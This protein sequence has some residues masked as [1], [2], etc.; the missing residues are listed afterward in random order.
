MIT[1]TDTDAES[2]IREAKRVLAEDLLRFVQNRGDECVFHALRSHLADQGVIPDPDAPQIDRFTG[3]FDPDIPPEAQATDPGHGSTIE[4]YLDHPDSVIAYL[5][6]LDAEGEHP[7]R[8]IVPTAD[9]ESETGAMRE[10]VLP[11][12]PTM[13]YR[14]DPTYLELYEIWTSFAS[15]LPD[16]NTGRGIYLDAY[17]P[18]P[19][20][21][22]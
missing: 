3:G 19:S 10:V 17:I 11:W 9:L 21:Q 12:R 6:A 2:R 18:A 4:V 15:R 22:G 14:P 8:L 16:P 13:D 5:P 1:D 7:R 20:E